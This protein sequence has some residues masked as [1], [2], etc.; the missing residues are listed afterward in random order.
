MKNVFI[1]REHFKNIIKRDEI[2][3]A[4]FS[5]LVLYLSK[6]SVLNVP[7]YWDELLVYV[8]P[9]RIVYERGLFSMIWDGSL[10]DPGNFFY[11]PF[12]I[13]LLFL[14]LLKLFGHSVWLLRFIALACVW[15]TLFYTYKIGKILHGKT[16]GFCASL[17]LFALPLLFTQ[18]TMIL[19][20]TFFMFFSTLFFF[21]LIQKKYFWTLFCV[22]VSLGFIRETAL[23]YTPLVFLFFFLQRDF[24]KRNIFLIL[25]PSVGVVLFFLMSGFGHQAFTEGHIGFHDFF[26]GLMKSF[27][28]AFLD[29]Y[30]GDL[31]YPSFFVMLFLFLFP[32]LK[33]EKKISYDHLLLILFLMFIFVLF[34]AL[35]KGVLSRYFHPIL[36][37]FTLLAFYPLVRLSRLFALVFLVAFVVRIPQYAF[38]S[39]TFHVGTGHETRMEYIEVIKV[40]SEAAQYLE[41]KYLKKRLW[42]SWPLDVMLSDSFFGYVKHSLHV[43]SAEEAQKGDYDIYVWA[44]NM[45]NDFSSLDERDR[46][47]KKENLKLV[48]NFFHKNKWVEIYERESKI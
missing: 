33:S 21:Q 12:G 8:N 25:S 7:Y 9:I 27:R 10:F 19:G 14:P 23:A 13:P 38:S 2:L 48:Q 40:H 41:N 34:F 24:K 35:D 47:L 1:S 30:K 32:K 29:D 31:F 17:S 4:V 22:G 42:T 15:G 11:H 18:S 45:R 3:F 5:G 46:W 39:N 26:A 6:M 37:Y 20:D 44:S 36:P 28:L 16:L 43:V